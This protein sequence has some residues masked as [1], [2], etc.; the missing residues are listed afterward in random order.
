MYPF[1]YHRPRSI[2]EAVACRRESADARYLAGGMTLLPVM[3]QRLASPAVLVDLRDVPGLGGITLDGDRLVIGAAVTHA[4]IAAS[5]LVHRSIPALAWAAGEL[6]DPQ[7]RH[8]GTIGGAVANNDPAA[9]Y[10]AALVALAATIVTDRRRIEADAFFVGLFRTALADDELVTAVEVPVPLAAGYAR[11]CQLA[12]RYP[13]VGVMAAKTTLGV[14]VAVTGA[15]S[16]VF[17]QGDL[18]AAL[19]ADFAAGAVDGITVP[20]AGLNHD[21][22][23]SAAYR[24]HLVA[25]LARRAVAAAA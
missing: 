25:V 12:S 14:R 5:P 11:F 21:I 9:D 16:V 20:A 1:A 6:G 7:V 8:L 19:A 18:E 15:A 17:R 3:K 10:P 23:G 24:A 22:H 4:A 13:L 2:A